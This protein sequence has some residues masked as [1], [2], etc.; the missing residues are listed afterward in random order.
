MVQPITAFSWH[1]SLCPAEVS[2]CMTLQNDRRFFA[3]P[4]LFPSV[5]P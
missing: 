5:G 2:D 1:R 3:W 4:N